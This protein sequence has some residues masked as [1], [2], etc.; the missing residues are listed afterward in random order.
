MADP[1]LAKGVLKDL[2]QQGY[3]VHEFVV[4]RTG[5]EKA[6][7]A[8]RTLKPPAKAITGRVEIAP[9]RIQTLRAALTSFEAL[10]HE[11]AAVLPKKATDL[12]EVLLAG[13]LALDASDIHLEPGEAETK[14]RL[15]LDGV[16]EDLSALPLGE[17]RE[18]T[19]RIKLVSALKLNVTESPQD[20]RFSIIIEEDEIEIRTSVLPGEHGENVVMRVLNPNRVA[21]ELTALGLRPDLLKL[22]EAELKA[23][24]G[25]I[26]TTGPTG[27]G[28]TTTLYACL[29]K[30]A[31]PAIKIITIEDPVEYHLPGLEQ[32]Q[33]DPANKYDF[34][35]ALRAVVRQDP[36]VILVGEIRDFETAEAALHAALTGHLVFSTLHTNNATGTVP[37]L[38]DLG[39]KPPI[40]APAINIAMAQR[41]VR[42]L[43]EKCKESYPPDKKLE[44]ELFEMVEGLP[45]AVARPQMKKPLALYRAK[46]CE[47]CHHTGYQGRI[48]V[49]EMFRFDEE[50]EKI[51]LERP[52][53]SALQ[54]AAL[55]QG[56]VTLRDDGLLRVLE[57]VTT[58]EEVERV[59]GGTE[60][61]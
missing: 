5:L 18:L 35:D 50:I 43:C 24:N 58:I 34:A 8:Y 1:A 42:R 30:I 20:G 46:G 61:E 57:G 25:M 3:E 11:I 22:L 17:N 13:A 45:E 41:L 60:A 15:R 14:I 28:K 19:E 23:P 9:E 54:Q 40:I 31:S 59:V 51:I 47:T 6:W 26:L 38:I 52:T 49:Y 7:R 39:A 53:E 55:K 29:K 33:I 27:S 32:T 2:A 56:M 4:S 16:L 37:R 21:L 36:D 44:R 48:A 10:R 12:L